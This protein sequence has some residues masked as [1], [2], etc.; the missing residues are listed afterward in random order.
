MRNEAGTNKDFHTVT[1]LAISIL[2]YFLK[3]DSN[4]EDGLWQKNKEYSPLSTKSIHGK[5]HAF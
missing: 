2:V 4:R 1:Y 5:N 3:L